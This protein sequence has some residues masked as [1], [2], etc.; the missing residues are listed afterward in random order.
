MSDAALPSSPD[1][2]APPSAPPAAAAA[3]AAAASASPLEAAAF[4]VA[5]AAAAVAAAAAP[6]RRI[7][8]CGGTGR[9][10]GAV[11]R[12]LLRSGAARFEVVVLTRDPA[13][14]R[15]RA[16]A[17]L[18]A[19]LARGDVNDRASLCA[20]F[21]GAH[22]VFGV[23]NSFVSSSA[24]PGLPPAADTEAEAQQGR[25]IVE[26]AHACGVAQLVLASVAC[27]GE[28]TGVPAFESKWQF[29]LFLQREAAAGRAP[30]AVTVLAP[31]GFFEN[32]EGTYTY[33]RQGIVPNMLSPGRKVQLVSVEDV[34]WFACAAFERPADFA[35]RRIELAGDE[36]SSDEVCAQI[37]E[38]RGEAGWAVVS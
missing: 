16:A 17:A 6:R 8:V 4:S 10:G 19:Q 33:L 28:A 18:G 11:L 37:A 31:V 7:V 14:E 12:H 13:G 38:L 22:G 35:G 24:F 15:A 20:A 34:G 36:L 3:A 9:Q 1:V 26:A 23:T 32:F 27:A 21:A 5:A 2:A 29:E 30:P 25:N